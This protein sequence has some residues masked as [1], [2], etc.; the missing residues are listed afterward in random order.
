MPFVTQAATF[1]LCENK[2]V[3]TMTELTSQ[4]KLNKFKILTAASYSFPT[5][6][7]F[8]CIGLF[9]GD[10]NAKHLFI[11]RMTLGSLLHCTV[12]IKYE[13]ASDFS[14]YSDV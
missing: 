12:I 4:N 11:E 2:V 8:I 14:L 3:G 5:F 10:V 13:F 9:D 1:H 6:Y 7:L